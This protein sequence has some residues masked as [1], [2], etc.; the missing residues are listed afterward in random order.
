MAYARAKNVKL[1]L[2][3]MFKVDPARIKI[4]SFGEELPLYD[5]HNT[6]Q[7]LKNRQARLYLTLPL[8]D[9]PFHE[10]HLSTYGHKAVGDLH[11]TQERNSDEEW[12]WP[13]ERDLTKL[14][15]KRD[16]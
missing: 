14:R 16:R 4:R 7:R 2:V 15:R 8:R 10:K 6:E 9:V 13:A 5:N 1:A 12:A 3:K 11:I